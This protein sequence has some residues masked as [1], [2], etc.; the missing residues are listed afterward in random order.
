MFLF[1]KIFHLNRKENK[2]RRKY[3]ILRGKEGKVVYGTFSFPGSM[4]KNKDP[5]ILE[6]EQNG[7]FHWI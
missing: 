7:W 3:G 4:E 2:L 5:P 1:V 6:I